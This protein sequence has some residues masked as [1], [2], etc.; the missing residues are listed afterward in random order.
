[1]NCDWQFMKA[2]D[3]FALLQVCSFISIFTTCVRAAHIVFYHQSFCPT[4]HVVQR[5]T[6]YVSDFGAK[7]LEEEAKFG[8]QGLWQTNANDDEDDA[9]DAAEEAAEPNDVK[10]RQYEL[11]KLRYYFAIAI[12]DSVS[13]ANTLYDQLNGAEV[14][15]SSVQLDLR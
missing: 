6:V 7:R 15:H 1:M 13:T 8:P 3:A 10:L 14:G 9:S 4:G 2:A 5:V 11:E 12:C